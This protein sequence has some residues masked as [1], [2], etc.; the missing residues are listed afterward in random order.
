MKKEKVMNV[1]LPEGTK[2]R[3]AE[4]TENGEIAIHYVE[5]YN[6]D[7]ETTQA[8]QEVS[9][10]IQKP[11]SLICGTEVYQKENGTNYWYCKIK[12]RDEFMFVD[13]TDLTIRDILY[14]TNGKKRRFTTLR[15][16]DFKAKVLEALENKPIERFRWIPAYEP[17][18]DENGNIQFVSGKDILRGCSI[19]DWEEKADSYSPENGSQIASVTTYFLLLLRWLKDGHA[20]I[21][22][23]ADDSTEI[24]YY[25]NSKNAKSRMRYE[26]TGERQFGGINGLVGNTFKIVKDPKSKSGFSFLG[27][28]HLLNGD[29]YPAANLARCDGYELNYS[30]N[31]VSIIELKK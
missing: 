18:E 26:K 10:A 7:N 28:I 5:E 2:Y 30:T 9:K 23:L 13:F 31:G 6:E 25:R 21:E 27:G 14:D 22:Q 24:G 4:V 17:S 11:T 20:T 29:E 1:R 3:N 15:Q 8:T 19:Y 16:M 12:G